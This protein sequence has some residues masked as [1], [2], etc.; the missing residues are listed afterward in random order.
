MTRIAYYRVSSRDQSIEAQRLAMGGDFA[1]EFSD[2][3]VSGA[4]QAGK[5]P[6]FAK[7]LEYIREGDSLH[8]YAIDRLGRDSIDVQTTVRKLLEKGVTI[9]VRG[10]G[11]IAATGIGGLL[12]V[13]LAQMAELERDRIRERTDAGREAARVHLA[14]HGKTHKGKAS[15]G[16]PVE[17]DAQAI[18]AWR[19]ENRASISATA[20]QFQVSDST[21]K[22]AL[23]APAEPVTA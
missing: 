2:E 12:L 11:Q 6:G 4:V 13:L 21:V 23:R 8:V 18:A 14:R 7:L 20:K 16:R 17:H 15:L 22:R 19:A 9:E 3:G 5:R 1:R 10:L